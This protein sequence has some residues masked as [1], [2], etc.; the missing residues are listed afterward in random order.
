MDIQSAAQKKWDAS[1]IFEVNAPAPGAPR[2]PA[3]KFF[4]NFPYPYMNGMLH[5]GHA[6]SLSKLEFA[7]AFHRLC[8]KDV[9]FPQAFHCTG[10]P[11][12][13]AATKL[14]REIEQYGCPPDFSKRDAEEA[15]E[16]TAE[17]AAPAAGEPVNKA[18]GKKTKLVAKTAGASQWDIL[19]MSGVAEDEI[20][21]FQVRDLRRSHRVELCCAALIASRRASALRRSHRVELCCAAPIGS[22]RDEVLRT[23]GLVPSPCVF[24]SVTV[25]LA[26]VVSLR[27]RTTG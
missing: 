22:S 16:E 2:N 18:K 3:G 8:G 10:M 6:F 9:L 25:S 15:A 17:E 12:Q 13:A 26:F 21:N 7:S 24:S 14:R 4:G 11:I 27:T 20:P 5:L 23:I 1:K 19:K